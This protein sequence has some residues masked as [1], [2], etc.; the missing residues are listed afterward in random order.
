MILSAIFSP[1]S[2][3]FFLSNN[4]TYLS[5]SI[6]ISSFSKV[7][8]GI[9][10]KIQIHFVLYIDFV[11]IFQFELFGSKKILNFCSIIFKKRFSRSLQAKQNNFYSFKPTFIKTRIENLTR[12][13]KTNVLFRIN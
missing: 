11:L 12:L 8:F 9:R 4:S 1:N 3:Y 7:F 10:R 6:A 13:I 2:L 5:N